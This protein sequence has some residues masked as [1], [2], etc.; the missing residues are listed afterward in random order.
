MFSAR[1]HRDATS[2]ANLEKELDEIVKKFKQVAALGDSR[3][4]ECEALRALA[5]V[6][7]VK[8]LKYNRAMVAVNAE[9]R[10]GVMKMHKQLQVTRDML[11]QCTAGNAKFQQAVAA[12]E[13]EHEQLDRE[14]EA[15]Q[16]KFVEEQMRSIKTQNEL[17]AAEAR[18]QST[19][20][21]VGELESLLN[22]F[23]DS[24]FV[25]RAS[26]AVRVRH[27][28]NDNKGLQGGAK[29]SPKKKKKKSN[30]KKKKRSAKKSP[31]GRRTSRCRR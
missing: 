30:S 22:D 19:S 26:K 1:L 21:S 12:M 29:R 8:H 2:T 11:K 4:G 15:A 28:L 13:Q 27:F 18:L 17:A 6:Y 24:N 25:G 3:E 16:S 14:L 7:S 5:E 9:F 23:R 31:K 20:D 10:D